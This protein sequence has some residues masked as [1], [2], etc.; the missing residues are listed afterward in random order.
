MEHQLALPFVA[1]SHHMA[2]VPDSF[3][4]T[5]VAAKYDYETTFRLCKQK[6]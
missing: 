2:Q 1:L 6:S 5:I 4:S 3:N